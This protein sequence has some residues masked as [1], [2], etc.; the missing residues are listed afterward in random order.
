M[1]G[2]EMV[3]ILKEELKELAEALAAG[4]ET[5]RERLEDMLD[6]A[7]EEREEIK[8]ILIETLEVMRDAGRISMDAYREMMESLG[9][10]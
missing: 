8:R 2:E 10:L 6:E 7:G 5:A 3:E 9:G 4:A 1:A